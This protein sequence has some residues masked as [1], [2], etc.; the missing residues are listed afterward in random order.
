[1]GIPFERVYRSKRDGDPHWSIVMGLT[2]LPGRKGVWMW[3]ASETHPEIALRGEVF[4]GEDGK[5]VLVGPDGR[6]TFEPLT[7]ETWEDMRDDV[8]GF[9]EIRKAINTDT[10]LQSWYWDEFAHDGAGNE[11]GQAEVLARLTERERPD[12]RAES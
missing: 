7:I 1:M 2:P 6:H 5:L 4:E 11:I 8:G 3:R 10:F 12:E 9:E